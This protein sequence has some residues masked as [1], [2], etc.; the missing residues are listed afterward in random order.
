[1]VRQPLARWWS[2]HRMKAKFAYAFEHNIWQGRESRSGSGSDLVQTRTLVAELPKLFRTLGVRSLLDI[3][4][5]DFNWMKQIDLSKIQY[6][7][8]DVVPQ[9][10]ER[11]RNTYRATNIDFRTLD[12]TSD[13][14]RKVDLILCRD[15]LVH[16][17]Y[18]DA[19]RALQNV[20]ASGSTFLL[21]TTFVNRDANSDCKTGEWRVLNLEKAPFSLPPPLYVLSEGCTE[22]DG[23]VHG[24]IVGA[25]EIEGYRIDWPAGGSGG[26]P[27]LVNVRRR[28][29][30]RPKSLIPMRSSMRAAVSTRR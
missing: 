28:F 1:M 16:M 2:R 18:E 15:C 24:Q 19:F 3:P 17:S 13:R 23:I 20:I 5:G 27:T 11:N 7:G 25:L 30:S 10:I 22:N 8:A 9:I 6:F 29:G 12:I 4:C 21:T 14:L 26:W